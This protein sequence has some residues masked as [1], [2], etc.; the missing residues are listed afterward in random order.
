M[1]GKPYEQKPANPSGLR[2]AIIAVGVCVVTMA[3]CGSA[4]NPEP[5]TSP[6]AAPSPEL[7]TPSP[8]PALT[9]TAYQEKL[10]D[11]SSALAPA[12]AHLGAAASL[13][14]ARAALDQTS[15]AASE[16][17]RLLNV[18]PPADVLTA[19]RDLLAGLRRLATDMSVLSG[20]VES[21]ELCAMPSVLPS[22][23]N[24][25]GVNSLRT[26][27]DELRSGR[28]GP[29]YQWGEFLPA[30]TPLPERR[31]AN[32]RLVDNQ[33]R[34]GRGQLKIDNSAEH[35]AVVKLVQGGRPIVSV[36][37]RQNSKTTVEQISDG[38]YEL[39][40]T[41]RTDWDDRLRTF[42]RSCQFQRFEQTANFSTTSVRGGIQYTVQ[43]VGLKPRIGGNARTE[44]IP[45]QSF[46]R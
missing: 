4:A 7:T 35:D 16:A 15:S 34:N 9:P 31:L 1:G 29:S 10:R 42:T 30:P 13:E 24:A 11:A 28:L 23:S 21:M 20:Q 25:T 8:P 37:V 17:A 2:T 41:S 22:F 46:P 45:A 19:H 3:G 5:S 33:R 44:K 14:D 12:F 6:A 38:N 32:G 26:V 40:Y 39:F 43:S 36:Y 18:D 27:R